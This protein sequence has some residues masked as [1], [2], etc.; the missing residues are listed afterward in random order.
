MP[1]YHEGLPIAAL[2]AASCGARML[3]S[4][5]PANLDIGLDP[6]NYFPVGDVAELTARLNADCADFQVDR[7][8]VRDRFSWD[9]AAAD[10]LEVYRAALAA[11]LPTPRASATPGTAG[12]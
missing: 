2:E 3:L 11:P 5:I 9:R 4:D 8:T 6:A 10:T 7:D 12:G 1:S